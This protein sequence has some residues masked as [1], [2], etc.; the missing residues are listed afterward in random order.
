MNTIRLRSE[1]GQCDTRMRLYKA[2]QAG[3]S[4]AF[5]LNRIRSNWKDSTRGET[6]A[7]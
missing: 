5:T 3:E 6:R 4:F 1:R 7:G 2:S